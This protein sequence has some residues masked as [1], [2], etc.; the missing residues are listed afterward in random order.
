MPPSRKQELVDAATRVFYRNGFHAS[1]LER[2]LQESGISRMTL[3]NHFKSK[4]DLIL[5]ALRHRDEVFRSGM[6]EFVEAKGPDARDRLLAV[7]DFHEQWF[8]GDDFC[9]CMF[10]N[11]AAEFDDP[12]SAPRRIA[13]DHKLE[14]MRYVRSLCEDLNCADPERA[15]EQIVILIEGAIVSAHVI[16][17]AW[18]TDPGAPAR[19]A[20]E[21]AMWVVERGRV[22]AD[23]AA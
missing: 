20:K 23:R 8:K 19:M 16:A 18:E 3:Y 12:A 1:G 10:I 6:M 4:D 22:E 5:A 7:F 14:I 17:R 13:A 15:A 21:M 2:I 9:G 11:A